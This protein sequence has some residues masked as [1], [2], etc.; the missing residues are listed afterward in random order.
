LEKEIKQKQFLVF[1]FCKKENKTLN[2]VDIFSFVFS[3][4]NSYSFSK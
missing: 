4:E 1:S 3:K 2:I